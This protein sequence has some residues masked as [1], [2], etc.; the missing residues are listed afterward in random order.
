[1]ILRISRP[2]FVGNYLQVTY[3][4]LGQWL[5]FRVVQLIYKE[6]WKQRCQLW[7]S[8][9]SCTCSVC[10]GI[11]FCKSF[12]ITKKDSTV[13][14]VE[15]TT[16]RTEHLQILFLKVLIRNTIHD[17]TQCAT[18]CG[19]KLYATAINFTRESPRTTPKWCSCHDVYQLNGRP[20]YHYD[21]KTYVLP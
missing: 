6:C 9:D 11:V 16:V 14:S 7:E 19:K 5:P 13:G 21:K 10:G 1:M 17:V 3:W 12:F 20:T 15:M 18:N 8:I 4:A 2:L